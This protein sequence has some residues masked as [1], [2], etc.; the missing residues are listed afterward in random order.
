MTGSPKIVALAGGVG[1]AKMADGLVR[2][3]GAE[4]VTVIVNTADDFLLYGLHIAPDLDTVLYTLAGIA[5]PVTG[6]GIA[7]DT[8]EALGA[9]A[10]YSRDPWFQVGDRDLATHMLRTEALRAGRTLTDVT[11]ELAA[12]LG[13]RSPILPMTDERVATLIETPDGP[14]EFQDYFVARRQRDEV[15]GVTFAGIESAPVTGSAAAAIAAAD[16]IVICPSNPIVSI[17]P[18]LLV[19]GLRDALVASDAPLVAVSPIVGGKALKGP[20]DRMLTSL[21]HESSAAGVAELYTG[22]VDGFVLDTVDRDLE[23]RITGDGM[24]TLVTDAVMRDPADRGRLASQIV[25]FGLSLTR[26]PA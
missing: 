17:G 20:A 11:A 3:A 23:S 24:R 2:A 19:P 10:R 8:H 12:A 26:V 1:G 13:V 4:Q 22:L 21:G 14:L 25:R 15:V 5:N 18:M 16:L 9:I 7:G 6:W